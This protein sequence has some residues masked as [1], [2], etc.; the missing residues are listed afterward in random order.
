MPL[1]PVDWH[2]SFG[3]TD[4]IFG[5]HPLDRKAARDVLKKT[6]AEDLGWED[7]ERTAR[8]YLRGEGC[9][10]EHINEQI[11]RMRDLSKWLQ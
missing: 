2:S 3:M 1:Q 6:W 5:G 7:I 11:R 4:R 8:E 10:Q 9:V